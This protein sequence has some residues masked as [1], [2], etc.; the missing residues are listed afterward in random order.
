MLQFIQRSCS[1]G[2]AFGGNCRYRKQAYTTTYFGYNHSQSRR[3]FSIASPC[4]YSMQK[5]E[6]KDVKVGN[7]V[8]TLLGQANPILNTIYILVCLLLST[9]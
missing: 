8:Y 7:E 9:F 1:T 2:F 5:K 4:G 3:N 6:A